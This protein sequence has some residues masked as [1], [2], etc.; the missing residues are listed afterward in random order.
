MSPDLSPTKGPPTFAR[1]WSISR[2]GRPTL[3]LN[4]RNLSSGVRRWSASKQ[5]MPVTAPVMPSATSPT[6]QELLAPLNSHACY[7]GDINKKL[8]EPK[9][10]LGIAIGKQGESCISGSPGAR[11]PLEAKTPDCLVCWPSKG[12]TPGRQAGYS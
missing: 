8:N 12:R 6:T 1:R 10:L 7:H 9:R 5:A 4:P 2:R 11:T 3:R